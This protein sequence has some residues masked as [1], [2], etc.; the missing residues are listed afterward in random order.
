MTGAPVVVVTG[1]SRGI[2]AAVAERFAAA[3]YQLALCDLVS[4]LAGV[5]DVLGQSSGHPPLYLEGDLGQPSIV[6]SSMEQIVAGFGRVDVLVTC[7]GIHR[8]GP[9]EAVDLDQWTQVIDVNLTGTFTCIQAAL[10]TM[11]AQGAGRII[12]IASELGLAGMAEYAAYCASKGGVIALTKALA[13][14]YVSRGILI[15]AVAPGPVLTDLLMASPEYDAG[16]TP[17]V[18]IGRYGRP[19]EIAEVVFGLA[20]DAGSFMVGQVISPNGGA[21]I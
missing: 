7:A 16:S 5:L 9:S 21:V 4:P 19:D 11:L 17:D 6:R 12:T 13:R 1:A 8:F 2:G 3:G 18:P 15:N 10:P 14:E 20:G